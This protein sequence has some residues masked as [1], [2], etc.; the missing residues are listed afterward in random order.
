MDRSVDNRPVQKS[1]LEEAM[2]RFRVAFQQPA[3]AL[4]AADIG[5]PNRF[6]G[7]WQLAR[8]LGRHVGWSLVFQPLMRAV[9]VVVL[10]KLG[11]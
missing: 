8:L 7:I 11:T 1:L 2:P 6:D 10:A 3:E 5:Q 9:Q 4:F